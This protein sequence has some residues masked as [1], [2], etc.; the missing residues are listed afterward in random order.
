M[1]R[2]RYHKR[3]TKKERELL[4]ALDE[5]VYKQSD[6]L[7]REPGD[8]IQDYLTKLKWHKEYLV[9]KHGGKKS[10]EK[11]IELS[12]KKSNVLKNRKR[13]EIR[14]KK[15]KKLKELQNDKLLD[16]DL[17]Q[18]KVEFGEVVLRPPELKA[19]PTK[20]AEYKK[21]AFSKLNFMKRFN[22]TGNQFSSKGV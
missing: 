17:W 9:A 21:V 8:S 11:N 3:I 20:K 13:H 1:A 5:K 19:K 16:K 6:S 22:T 7:A 12:D 4:K 15:K 14:M 18:D 2:K 10:R